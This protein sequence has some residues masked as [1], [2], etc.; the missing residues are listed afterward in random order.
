M[1]DSS[2]RLLR[3]FRRAGAGSF[4]ISIVVHLILIGGATVYVVSSVREQRK[5]SFQGGS[6]ASPGP[7][8]DVQHKVQMSHQQEKLSAVT[9]RL[10]VDS[11]NASVSLPDL[12][13]TPGFS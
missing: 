12:P 8:K 9:Q 1:S 2:N 10:A 4:L 7:R 13:D 3:Y 11:P 5:A 6:T